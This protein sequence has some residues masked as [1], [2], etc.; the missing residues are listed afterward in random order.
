MQD[1]TGEIAALGT[2]LF[3]AFGST[4]F[5]F[6]GRAFGSQWVNRVRLLL[7]SLMIAIVHVLLLGYLVPQGVSTESL[8]WLSI[9]G[10]VGLVLGDMCLMQAFVMIGPRLSML[11]MALAPMFSTVIAWLFLNETLDGQTV[12]GI[13][14]A[15]AGVIIVVT[16]RTTAGRTSVAVSGREYRIG[17]LFGLG[18]SLGQAGGTILSR[19]GL[20]AGIEPISASLIRLTVAT[21]VIWIIAFLR[22]QAGGT[23]SAIQAKPRASLQLVAATIAGPVIGVW[24]SLVAVQRTS[25]GIA[26]TLSALTPIFLIPISYFVFKE[27]VT[28]QAIFGTIIATIGTVLLF[29]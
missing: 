5:T 29:I 13:I 15:V 9:S 18:G 27:H 12:I 20:A 26:S 14:L 1:F 3:F 7:A 21:V 28:R 8:G 4:L 19:L 25:V 11:M 17:L 16:E 24:L 2:A 23:F 22:G 6:A 10:I